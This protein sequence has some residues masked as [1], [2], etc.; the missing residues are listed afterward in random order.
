MP[1]PVALA[2]EHEQP[3]VV[4]DPVDDG[5]VEKVGVRADSALVPL[6][7]TWIPLPYAAI[8]RSAMPSDAAVVPFANPICRDFRF[9]DGSRSAA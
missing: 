8:S 1:Q 2:L 3:L 4:G 6:L 7:R 5:S 9:W